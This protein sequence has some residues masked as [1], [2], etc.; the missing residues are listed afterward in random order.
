MAASTKTW[1]DGVP[2]QCEADDLNGF[3]DE[4][5]N[6][7]TT[8]G[9]PLTVGDNNQTAEA[10]ST[11]ASGAYFYTDGGGANAHVLSPIGAK[12]APK[13]YFD[14]MHISFIP[15][16]TNTG[17]TTAKVG[18]LPVVSLLSVTGTALTGAEITSGLYV[19]A[20]FEAGSFRLSSKA[21][22]FTNI[23]PTTTKGDIIAREAIEDVRLAVG[24]DGQVLTADSAEPMGLRWETASAPTFDSIAPTNT[25]GDLIVRDA[26]T[27]IRLPVGVN[28]AVLT[29]DSVVAN[30]VKWETPT[31]P[32]FDQLAPTTTKGD[33][34]VRDATNNVRIPVGGNGTVLTADATVSDGVK[35]VSVIR[36]VASIVMSAS[37]SISAPTKINFN[38]ASFDT[39]SFWVPGPDHILIPATGIYR[40]G[41]RCSH[42]PI[43]AAFGVTLVL[44]GAGSGTVALLENHRSPD[45]NSQTSYS[46]VLQQ[47]TVGTTLEV[48]VSY[49]GIAANIGAGNEFSIESIGA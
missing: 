5:N 11:Y 15:Q 14:G 36:P 46:G 9:L 13:G 6:L 27:N 48:H 34:I 18:S 33:L 7:I 22:D 17:A 44:G 29:A 16:G 41:F 38:T 32:T 42:D 12:L 26:T 43:S 23:S 10:I 47:F 25:K 4:N 35:W 1:V 28:G 2:P 49:N 45:G 19:S 30:G 20:F 31:V 24:T 40:I 21:I 39:G 8:A 37:Q 3:K